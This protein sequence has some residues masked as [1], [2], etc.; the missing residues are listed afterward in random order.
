MVHLRGT[1]LDIP[2]NYHNP[3]LPDILDAFRFQFTLEHHIVNFHL[4]DGSEI[5][6]MLVSLRKGPQEGVGEIT[7]SCYEMGQPGVIEIVY[8]ISG[9]CG[10]AHWV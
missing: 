6:V 7:I 8:D 5:H 1:R 3:T 4:E 9:R 2:R 10:N